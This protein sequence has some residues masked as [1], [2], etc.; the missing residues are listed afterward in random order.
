MAYEISLTPHE[1]HLLIEA[2]RYAGS[3]EMKFDGP[4]R[5]V[6]QDVGERAALAVQE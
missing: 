3:G 1:L 4:E 5:A 6:I 2:C